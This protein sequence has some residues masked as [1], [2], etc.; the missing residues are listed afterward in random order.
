[1]MGYKSR[2]STLQYPELNA[3]QGLNFT[4]LIK[5]LKPDQTLMYV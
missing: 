2:K 3:K 5:H 1:M 4:G